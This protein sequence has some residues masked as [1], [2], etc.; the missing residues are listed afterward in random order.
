MGILIIFILGLSVFA[1]VVT[2]PVICLVCALVARAR[3]LEV[4]KFAGAGALFGAFLFPWPYVLVRAYGRPLPIA[5]MGLIYFFAYALW[6][7][8]IL[9]VV[10]GILWIWEYTLGTS[11]GYVASRASVGSA[12]TMSILYGCGIA[13]CG[14]AM[15]GSLKG[16][17]RRYQSDRRHLQETLSTAHT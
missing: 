3:K 12:V 7:I 8:A 11:T 14:F 1:G 16:L 6:S 10:G 9:S 17:Y 5:G 2:A 13:V 4:W 15:F